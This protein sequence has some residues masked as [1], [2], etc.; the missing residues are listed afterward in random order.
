MKRPIVLMLL[1][2]GLACAPAY[3]GS[4]VYDLETSLA[5][6]ACPEGNPLIPNTKSRPVLYGFSALWAAAFTV[7]AEH[8]NHKKLIYTLSTVWRLFV[9]TLNLRY[10]GQEHGVVKITVPISRVVGN[11]DCVFSTR[12]H[13]IALMD[14]VVLKVPGPGISIEV[15]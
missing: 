12:P 2:A 8:T 14:V 1:L 15:D 10:W 3:Y 9:G 5:C 13:R 4:V 7:A 11:L 6:K